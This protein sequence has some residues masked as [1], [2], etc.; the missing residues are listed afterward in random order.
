MLD[1]MYDLP[2]NN[3][4]SYVI[5]DEAVYGRERTYPIVEPKK[6]SA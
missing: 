6:N 4:A 5:T 2:E 3:G 1:V